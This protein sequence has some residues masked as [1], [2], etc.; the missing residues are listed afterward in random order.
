MPWVR[1][2]ENAMEHPKIAG[3]SDAAFRLWVTGL[4]YCQKFLTDGYISDVALRGLRAYSL[5]RKAE[6]V[7]AGLWHEC[8]AGVTVHDFPDW[9]D[10]RERVLAARRHARERMQRLRE[11]SREQQPNTKRTNAEVPSGYVRRVGS[12]EGGVGETSAKVAHDGPRLRVWKWQHED[13]SKR[14]GAKADTFDL[15]GWY[16]RLESELGR[17][18][19]SFA[20]PWRWLQQRLYRDADLPLPNLMGRER[21]VDGERRVDDADE[22]QKILAERERWRREAASA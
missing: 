10:S 2:D 17:T 1:I 4:A 7:R 9:N 11:G 16:S 3:L 14:L 8:D 6:I 13:L 5:K 21:R 22:T 20:D 19:E 18:G 12:S 15:L